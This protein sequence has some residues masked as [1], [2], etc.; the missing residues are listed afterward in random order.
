VIHGC[1]ASLD[2]HACEAKRNHKLL[3]L[4]CFA[5]GQAPEPAA[6]L[7]VRIA[8]PSVICTLWETSLS[9]SIRRPSR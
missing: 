2:S 5:C 4:H 7:L 8:L 3:F 6:E 1:L 9:R